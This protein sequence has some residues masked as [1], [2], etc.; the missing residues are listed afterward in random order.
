MNYTVSIITE[1]ANSWNIHPGAQGDAT[2]RTLLQQCKDRSQFVIH[3]EGNLIYYLYLRR[4]LDPARFAGWCFVINGQEIKEQGK[5]F[6][7]FEMIWTNSPLK[8]GKS[9]SSQSYQG[10]VNALRREFDQAGFTFLDL[11]PYGFAGDDTYLVDKEVPRSSSWK[12][13]WDEF[14]KQLHAEREARESKEQVEK[15]IAWDDSQDWGGTGETRRAYLADE[16]T[17]GHV[18]Y[19]FMTVA[20]FLPS[21]F[22]AYQY[23]SPEIF[24]YCAVV[25]GVLLLLSLLVDGRAAS[26]R[27]RVTLGDESELGFWGFMAVVESIILSIVLFFGILAFEGG[28]WDWVWRL[29]AV[30]VSALV[31]SAILIG[32]GFALPFVVYPFRSLFLMLRRGKS[33]SSK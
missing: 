20:T 18:P 15:R 9:S 28:F 31:L 29:V 1:S 30:L 5:L 7:L 23:L 11:Q 16:E 2:L 17:E 8:T 13:S 6:M 27:T 32:L 22:I 19:F 25:A 24:F 12:S 4:T 3:R 10:G 26:R 21:L 14:E 33:R